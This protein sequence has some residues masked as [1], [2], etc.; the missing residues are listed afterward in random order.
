MQIGNNFNWVCLCVFM[1]VCV[2]VQIITFELLKL[3]TSFSVNRYIL[4]ISRSSVS[5]M[6]IGSRSRSK[7]KL[8][9]FYLTVSSVCLYSTKTYLKGQC[10][11]KVKVKIT[12]Y[13]GQVTG[14]QFS[15]YL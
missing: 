1:S 9:Y 11:L 12:Q 4:T 14:H 13:Q 6:V 2:S 10:H 7:E 5:I 8:T 3:E 15:I